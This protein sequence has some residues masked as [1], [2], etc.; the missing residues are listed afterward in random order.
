M[1]KRLAFVA[2]LFLIGC[3][4]LL[5]LSLTVLSG[6][7]TIIGSVVAAILGILSGGLYGLSVG[8]EA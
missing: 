8:H 5:T 7:W 6:I 4:L 3:T 2:F 1:N